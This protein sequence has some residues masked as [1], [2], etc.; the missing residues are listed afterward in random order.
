VS[1]APWR[2]GAVPFWKATPSGARES[3]ARRSARQPLGRRAGRRHARGR[4]RPRPLR[5]AQ[6]PRLPARA[7]GATRVVPS[8]RRSSSSASATRI[9]DWRAVHP[10]PVRRAAST[11]RGASR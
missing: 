2:P 10:V 8:D 6:P 7:A 3:S 5:R 4:L 9:G 1:P 11:R